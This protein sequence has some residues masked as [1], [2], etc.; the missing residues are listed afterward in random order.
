MTKATTTD[1]PVKVPAAAETVFAA[2][3]AALPALKAVPPR[4]LRLFACGCCRA[5]WDRLNP[6][7]RRAVRVAELY[8]DGAA[9]VDELED[10]WRACKAAEA[11]GRPVPVAA[12][13]PGDRRF[14]QLTEQVH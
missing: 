1:T 7:C 9:T 11:D 14:Y 10:A 4:K 12:P 5:A 6:V 13:A 2:T 3:T 8:A